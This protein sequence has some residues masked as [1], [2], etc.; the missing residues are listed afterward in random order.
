MSVTRIVSVFFILFS[1]LSFKAGAQQPDENHM[2]LKFINKVEVFA[3]PS[4]SFNYGN[5]FIENY[6][7]G[8]IQNK[9]L[10]KYGY[11]LGV[12]FY[13]SLRNRIEINLRIQLDQ[14]GTNAELN[15]PL[16]PVNNNT[17]QIISSEYTYNYTT[18]AIS[19]RLH[20]D[21]KSKFDISLGGYIS[22]L[23]KTKGSITYFD[24]S[25]GYAYNNFNGR[26]WN[27]FNTD[28]GIN[29]STFIPGKKSFEDYDYGAILCL[30]YRAKLNE[31]HSL[32][33]QILYSHG[34]QNVYNDMFTENLPEKNQ[35]ISIQIG[36]IYFRKY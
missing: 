35:A 32:M 36:Y 17:R 12:G 7:N 31:A 8:I 24:E 6:D 21:K 22:R 19:P 14:K 27:G 30:S 26:Q 23:N 13:H 3:G 25:S 18:I 9:R 16:N 4:L 28:G 2:P 1:T 10:Q 33:F 5:K 11:S 15:H 29:S 20:I 34:L